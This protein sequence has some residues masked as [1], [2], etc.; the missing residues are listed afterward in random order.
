V[1]ASEGLS[2]IFRQTFTSIGK[3]MSEEQNSQEWGQEMDRSEHEH[4]FNA[5]ISMSKWGSVAVTL[6]LLGLLIFVYN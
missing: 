2:A 4:T 5:F 6:I 1:L 3:I